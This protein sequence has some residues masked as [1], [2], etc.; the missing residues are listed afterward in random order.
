MAEGGPIVAGIGAPRM[1]VER[2]RCALIRRYP[3]RDR[4]LDIDEVAFDEAT[5]APPRYRLP[6]ADGDARKS[7]P[8]T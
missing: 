2:K 1:H 8:R 3:R 7:D 4:R 5:D 6:V